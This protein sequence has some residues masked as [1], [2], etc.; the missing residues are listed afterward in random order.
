MKKNKLTALVTAAIL[1]FS[2]MCMAY[3]EELSVEK[4]EYDCITIAG[5]NDF[6]SVY[7]PY[8]QAGSKIYLEVYSDETG[9]KYALMDADD[10]S[11]YLDDLEWIGP[12]SAYSELVWLQKDGQYSVYNLETK[13]EV[14][15]IL[16][17]Y[18]LEYNGR[19]SEY[20]GFVTL[21]SDEKLHFI[22]NDG[23]IGNVVNVNQESYIDGVKRLA[24]DVYL[25]EGLYRLGV[26]SSPYNFET[27]GIVNTKGDVIAYVDSADSFY[28]NGAVVM[29][30]GKYGVIGTDGKYL[31]SCT[32]DKITYKSGNYIAEKN[33][34][35]YEF[36]Y[37]CNK[38]ST[39]TPDYSL[40]D[41]V[42]YYSGNG[43]AKV[44][45]R[46]S[47]YW[48]RKYGLVNTKNEIVIPMEYAYVSANVDGKSGL[49][50]VC[51]STEYS[52]GEYLYCVIGSSKILV[53]FGTYDSISRFEDGMALVYKDG[54]CGF[55]D[56][57]CNLAIPLEYDGANYF[58]DGVVEVWKGDES[59]Y[60]NKNNEVVDGNTSFIGSDWKYSLTGDYNYDD[61][62]IIKSYTGGIR[63]NTTGQTIDISDL[64]LIPDI[65][66]DNG[67]CIIAY[68]NDFKKLY[69]LIIQGES[70]PTVSVSVN[71][72]SENITLESESIGGVITAVLYDDDGLKEVKKYEYSEN[73]DVTFDDLQSGDNIKILWW[74][75]L[76]NLKPKCNSYTVDVIH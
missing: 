48:D 28:N 33:G 3:A 55:I 25:G 56:V 36:D 14:C 12:L 73:I 23:V 39:F 29:K 65:I 44:Y 17:N 8:F 18:G 51:V 41:V 62:Y 52:G 49:S 16:N 50:V 38:V 27:I 1:S 69:R 9:E 66:G 71:G 61:Y 75:S 45:N 72:I 5:Q 59:F 35:F 34:V 76:K 30:D 40:Y 11:M 4:M 47:N 19:F 10:G 20:G 42:D 13:E 57:N 60:I 7:Q 67:D 43:L 24:G 54:K 46:V 22:S 74:E 15:K 64:G 21:T 58:S 37:K 31:L 26:G 6:G 53:P 68:S 70:T 32:Y 2:C 63:V